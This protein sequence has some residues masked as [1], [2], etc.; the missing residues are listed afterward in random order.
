MRDDVLELIDFFEDVVDIPI[1]P[2]LDTKPILFIFLTEPSK[3]VEDVSFSFPC[4]ELVNNTDFRFDWLVFDNL[5]SLP[6][7]V[8]L[9]S[10]KWPSDLKL[11][12]DGTDVRIVAK[13][14]TSNASRAPS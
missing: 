2:T 10:P 9:S 12:F 13:A 1:R 8:K 14:Q 6:Q 3:L 4:L 5:I 7:D 11:K